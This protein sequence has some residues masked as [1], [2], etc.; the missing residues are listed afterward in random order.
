MIAQGMPHID[1]KRQSRLENFSCYGAILP[2]F[3]IDI[4]HKLY[5]NIFEKF[6]PEEETNKYKLRAITCADLL[7]SPEIERIGYNSFI[8][9]PTIQD[10]LRNKMMHKDNAN[11]ILQEIGNFMLS[12]IWECK[13]HFP[14]LKHLESYRIEGNIILNPIAEAERVTHNIVNR[15]NRLNN[16]NDQ[17]NAVGYYLKVLNHNNLT[18]EQKKLVEFLNIYQQLDQDSKQNFSPQIE[19]L[20]DF[21]SQD[22]NSSETITIKLPTNIKKKILDGIKT[23]TSKTPTLHALI[24]GINDYPSYDNLRLRSAVNDST[25]IRDYLEEHVAEGYICR[26]HLLINEH[27][28]YNKIQEY[29]DYILFKEIKGGDSFVFY[30]SGQGGSIDNL[31]NNDIA[32]HVE[33]Q[34]IIQNIQD[35]ALILSDSTTLSL[36]EV[37][38]QINKFPN[39]CTYTL[40]LDTD[41]SYHLDN[42]IRDDFKEINNIKKATSD[43]ISKNIVVITAAKDTQWALE[44]TDHGYFT[45]FLF[46]VLYLSEQN[47]TNQHLISAI[48]IYMDSLNS[49]QRTTLSVF[50]KSSVND[51][52]LNGFIASPFA[53][54]VKLI[55]NNIDKKETTLTL[56]GMGLTFLPEVIFDLKHLKI[57]D[58]S[59]NSIQH[60]PEKI[61]R[62]I[63]LEEL[64][65]SGNPIDPNELNIDKLSNLKVL[66]LRNCNLNYFPKLVLGLPN[67][68]ELD[69][70]NN[71]IKFIPNQLRNLPNLEKLDLTG[72][73]VLNF[74]ITNL[75]N[76]LVTY[77]KEFPEVD[78]SNNNIPIV[79]LIALDYESKL[80]NI[81]PEIEEVSRICQQSGLEVI[82]LTNPKAAELNRSIYSNQNRLAILHF[83]SYEMDVL[84]DSENKLQHMKPDDWIEFFK[85]IKIER[86]DTP[87]L[88]VNCCYGEEIINV[89]LKDTFKLGIGIKDRIDDWT[90]YTFATQFYTALAID[91]KTIAEA[92]S[93]AQ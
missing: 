20:K 86:F 48:N 16:I 75:G 51:N 84:T 83:A 35:K 13:K 73:A 6:E 50:G 67:L 25:A 1:H 57:L 5:L 60:L 37:L 46:K 29:F 2:W 17:K 40:L 59:D 15:F 71:A 45:K 28:N 90:A 39:D 63:N 8:I 68:Q 66:K 56:N 76:D 32:S 69:L 55:Q 62:L 14:S 21:L 92:M 12:Y 23:N 11:E 18:V 70:A 91:K 10:K 53:A 80:P 88:F 54:C 58:I 78:N 64:H 85:C 81:L 26:T 33:P 24:L 3:N 42:L 74:D 19:K 7:Q 49:S 41:F 34:S 77:L 65:L 30:Y 22:H 43:L 27:A 93:Y 36:L 89:L 61:G 44:D 38:R 82:Q 47:I 79:M 4:L 72:N 52:F 9:H 31:K 87:L